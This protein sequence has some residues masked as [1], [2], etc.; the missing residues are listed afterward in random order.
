LFY[1][2]YIKFIISQ[3]RPYAEEV[4]KQLKMLGMHVD[5]MFPNDQIPMNKV[6]GNIQSRGCLYGILITPINAERKS[7]TLTVSETFLTKI[8]LLPNLT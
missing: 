5:L 8:V 1:K 2:K 6:L 3:I 4:E 7:L